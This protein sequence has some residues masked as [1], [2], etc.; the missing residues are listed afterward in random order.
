MRLPASIML[1]LALA[2]MGYTASAQDRKGIRF[3]N[4][5]LYT[6]TAFQLSPAGTDTWG[7]DQCRND[8]MERSITTNACGSQ[9]SNPA[10]TT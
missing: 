1:G 2:F 8:R 5:T 3:W 7:P 4:L 10:A 6:I 9:A